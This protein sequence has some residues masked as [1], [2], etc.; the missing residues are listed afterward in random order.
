M[1]ES[2]EVPVQQLVVPLICDGLVNLGI[3]SF[4]IVKIYGRITG[5]DLPDWQQE[6]ELEAL[7]NLAV[8]TPQT[9]IESDFAVPLLAQCPKIAHLDGI[10]TPAEAKVIDSINKKLNCDLALI[11]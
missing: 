4:K 9:N 8:L 10:I 6:I 5:K 1:L 11:K 7:V 2:I 3:Q